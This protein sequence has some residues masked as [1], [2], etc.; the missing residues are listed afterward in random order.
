MINHVQLV[1]YG[2]C[3]YILIVRIHCFGVFFTF[4][5]F[6]SNLVHVPIVLSE[7]STNRVAIAAR[8][9]SIWPLGS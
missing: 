9:V 2:L 4:L 8:V 3:C 7:Y 5:A 1:I 6:H